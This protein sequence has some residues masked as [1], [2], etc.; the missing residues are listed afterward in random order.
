MLASL[1]TT[2]EVHRT[3][4]DCIMGWNITGADGDRHY[5]FYAW[6]MLIDLAIHYG[7]PYDDPSEPEDEEGRFRVTAQ[8]AR[9]FADA[10]ERALPDIP[11]HDALEHKVVFH[12]AAPGERLLPFETPVSPF[13]F[14]SGEKKERLKEFIALCRRGGLV[15]W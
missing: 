5:T 4:E 11:D 6:G 2:H 3:T 12:P 1:A 8:K 14:F 10:L 9:A 13:E 15:I 7:F